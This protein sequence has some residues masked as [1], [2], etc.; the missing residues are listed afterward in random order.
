VFP[1]S[2][3]VE[4]NDPRNTG[5][6]HSIMNLPGNVQ[7]DVVSRYVDSLPNPPVRHYITSDARLAW[8]RRSVELSVVGQNLWR[9]RQ[10]EFGVTGIPRSV[11]GK[12]A[13]RR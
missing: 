12:I 3:D 2:A 1:I 11:Y 5:L 7:F 8:E 10:Q 13:V 4:G 6:L 9:R